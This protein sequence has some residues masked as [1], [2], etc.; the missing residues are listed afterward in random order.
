MGFDTDLQR[1]YDHGKLGWKYEELSCGQVGTLPFIDCDPTNPAG[2]GITEQLLSEL[3]RNIAI[4]WNLPR[5]DMLGMTNPQI[6]MRKIYNTLEYSQGNQG[7]EFTSVLTDAERRA[8]I[9][10]LKTL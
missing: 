6:E 1:A 3:Y 10:Y 5:V 2:T 9:E 4:L 7:H 8:I